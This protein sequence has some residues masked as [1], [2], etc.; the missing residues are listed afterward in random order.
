MTVYE[1]M[2]GPERE[3]ASFLTELGVYWK[4]EHPIYILDDHERPRLWTPDFYLSQ[5]GIYIE[6]CGTKRR[7]YKF[8]EK[9]YHK[10]DYRVIFLHY[11][12]AEDL[13]KQ[14]LI[15][16]IK[17]VQDFRNNLLK[18]ISNDFYPQDESYVHLQSHS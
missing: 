8:R 11:Y 14:Y 1:D 16:N 12:K 18:T 7:Q 15:G 9:M 6:V 17:E 3:V 13:W 4:F 10:N 2:S 5:F